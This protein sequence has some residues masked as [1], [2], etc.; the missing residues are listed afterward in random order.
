MTQEIWK[1]VV[2]FEGFYEVSSFGNV[3]S[4]DRLVKCSRGE[5]QRLWKGRSLKQTVA[6]TRGYCQ[7]SLCVCGKPTKVYVHALVAQA[8]YEDRNE[9]VNHIDGNKLNNRADN[10]EWVS[11]SYNNSH[12]FAIGLKF[13]SGGRS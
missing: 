1:P 13:P 4:C 12:A 9:T 10:L 3:R 7:V 2:G 11:Y 6:A 8:F 5:K